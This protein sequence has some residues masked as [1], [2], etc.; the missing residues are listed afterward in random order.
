[1][2]KLFMVA[3][4]PFLLFIQPA[5]ADVFIQNDQKYVS[6]DGSLH[7]VGEI[8]NNSNSPLNQVEIT[9]R[10]LDD[11]GFQIG[12]ALSLIHI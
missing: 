4:L 9:A 8:E 10:L 5:F 3:M 2:K 7:I 11:N 12:Q 6:T 1:M